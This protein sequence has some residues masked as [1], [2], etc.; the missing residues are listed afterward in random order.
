MARLYVSILVMKMH[1]TIHFNEYMR[2]K[3]LIF[4]SIKLPESVLYLLLI[5]SR[6]FPSP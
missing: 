3:N 6:P 1:V 2:A 4:I 5:N